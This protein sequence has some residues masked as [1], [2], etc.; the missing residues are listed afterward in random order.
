[1]RKVVEE[2][3]LGVADSRGM[4]LELVGWETHSWPGIGRDAQDVI[5]QQL[6]VPD[7]VVGIFWKRLGTPTARASS[8]SV[9]EIENALVLRA[10]GKPIDVL[11]YFNEAVYSPQ[12]H[13]LD[14][15][16][17][18]FKFRRELIDR[19]L[20]LSTY[21][22]L[23]DFRE[24][25]RRHLTQIVRRLPD[26]AERALSDSEQ[27]STRHSPAHGGHDEPAIPEWQFL[28]QLTDLTVFDSDVFEQFRAEL[29]SSISARYP[30]TVT[31]EEFLSQ[32]NLRIGDRLTR[33]GAL[34]FARNPTAAC[35]TSMV[36]CTHYSGIDRTARSLGRE[37]FDGTVP[38]QI[39]AAHQFVAARVTHGEAPSAARAQ[40]ET[41]YSYPM[42]AVREVIAN[43]LVHR[44][45]SVTDSC[46]HVRLFDDRLE[47][48]S[49]GS[50]FGR[51][52]DPAKQYDLSVLNGQ[53]KKRNYRLAH[54]LSFISL[55]EGEGS[56]I[57]AAL[58]SC[59]ANEN[60]EPTVV[61]EDG[62][63]TVIVRRRERPDDLGDLRSFA[64]QLKLLRQGA[65][66][67]SEELANLSGLPARVVS[68][69]ERAITLA[70]LPDTVQR[71]ADAL[72][73]D[74]PIRASFESAALGSARHARLSLNGYGAIRTR[75]HRPWSPDQ[76]QL[77]SWPGRHD[78]IVN[79]VLSPTAEHLALSVGQLLTVSK[80]SDHSLGEP[81]LKVPCAL[82]PL[83]TWSPSGDRL[84]F[85]DD[86]GNGRVL[87]LSGRAS[88]ASGAASAE[89]LGMSSAMAFA[90]GGDRLAMLVPSLGGMTL[91][92]IGPDGQS[93]WESMVTRSRASGNRTEGANLA[94]SPD[95][96]FLACAT[97]TPTVWLID[98]ADGRLVSQFTDHS[99]PV[100]GLDWIDGDWILSASQD[101]TL[102]MWR[103][104]GAAPSTVVET[105]PAAG[106]TF[107]RGRGTALIWS[108]DGDLYAWSLSDGPAQ[109]W[110]RVPPKRS[111]W[112][113]FTRIAVSAADDLLVLVDPGSAKLVLVRDW[114]QTVTPPASTTTYSNA[115]VLLLGDTGVGKSGLAMVLAGED[116]RATESTHGR[117]IW[118]LPA[119][120]EA[121]AQGSERDVLVWD[122]AGQPGYRVVHQLHLGGAVVALIVFD[123]K[124]ETAP[125]SGVRHWARAIRHAHPLAD[126][127]LPTFL[128]AARI[129]RGGTAVSQDRIRQVMADFA[130]DDF[131]E[132]SAMEG[133]GTD[134]LRS[135]ILAAIDWERIPKI[136]STALFA[137]VKQFVVNQKLLGNLLTPLEELHRTFQTAVPGALDLLQAEEHLQ[138]PNDEETP[139]TPSAGL[140][141]VFEG[142]V[143]RLESA[144][145]VKRLKF[146]NL[147]LLQPELLDAYASAIVNAAREEPDGLGSI[148]ETKVNNVEFR[149]PAAERVQDDFSERLLVCATLEEL[150]QSEL[151]LREPTEDGVQ[152]VF[153]SAYRRDLPASQAPRGDGVVFRFEGPIDNIYATLIVRLSRS[154][155]FSRKATWQSAARFTAGGGECTVNLKADGE[156][157]AELW[158]GYDRVPD[159]LRLQFEGFVHS[160]L[161]RRAN[162]GT[163]T[164]ERQYS[165]PTDGTAF[166]PEQIDHARRLGRTSILCPI[167]ESRVSLRD[168][169]ESAADIELLTAAM[170]ASADQGRETEAASTV[171]R[172][173]EQVAEFDLFLCYNVADKPA[174]RQLAQRL[175][176]RGLRPWL[177]ELELQPGMPWRH[178]LQEQIH[179]IP[180]AAVIVGSQAGPWQDQELTAFLRKFVERGCPVIPVL[181]PDVE[182]PDLPEFL[183]ALTWVDLGVDTPDPYY[184][185][186]WGITGRRP[187]R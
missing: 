21:D 23:E 67:T 102:R 9:E 143:A 172:G 110:H 51:D 30:P 180:A 145:L 175:R 56:G 70:P 103:A 146:G 141:A 71:L 26:V 115:K 152:L 47:V 37:T 140:T 107:V 12:E 63:V 36:K 74:G 94:W 137:A 98:A 183:D 8:G 53:S 116:F 169:Y 91:A 2:L 166:T 96:Q 20:L 150:I 139:Q 82:I 50:W 75:P 185:L 111:L 76:I 164:R 106:M 93:L 95:G 90:P 17:G 144:G 179:T 113:H 119:A 39:I 92:L 153:P 6:A 182:R 14:Q 61:Q 58:R 65:S 129:D 52:L 69:L 123:S 77:N 174:V 80:I 118:H 114:Y 160:H 66:L 22:G 19:G 125:M 68:D 147:I 34:L 48:S 132:T 29:R 78:Q 28:D 1:L 3:N 24:K 7:I 117:R 54:V 178:V 173:K 38:A 59:A 155:R 133:T 127:G 156:G 10:A 158:M 49:P 181:L 85:R 11:V 87:H 121:D 162:P 104:D 187:D 101:A 161:E 157:K 100:T 177:D 126:G 42:V 154:D 124:N 79:A 41:S 171:L 136:T 130:I 99:L 105:I 134:L 60:P 35:P 40:L 151:V 81:L 112:A 72:G 142:C 27:S 4:I 128:V 84:V 159:P 46:V 43:A 167:C 149:V 64:E 165:C 32:E 122:L 86:N 168:D 16:A 120:D 44:D 131:F 5:N 135:R 109:L 88:P 25:V 97:G 83:L 18:L 31:A 138:Q 15:I 108:G 45:Y 176:E 170:E 73:L 33:T 55:V 163:V 184:Q 13:E 62:F 148:M 57:P 89:V 186:E